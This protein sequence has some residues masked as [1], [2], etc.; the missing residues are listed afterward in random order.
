MELQWRGV[1]T[2]LLTDLPGQLFA[3][4]PLFQGLLFQTYA[5]LLGQLMSSL[6]GEQDICLQ[7]VFRS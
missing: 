4:I 7:I 2:A 1:T 3:V 6:S 5:G